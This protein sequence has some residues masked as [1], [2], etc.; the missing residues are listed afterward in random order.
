MGE[1]TVL[2]KKRGDL[3]KIGL[4]PKMF[5]Q[6]RYEPKGQGEYEGEYRGTTL[7]GSR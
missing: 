5:N 4:I 6:D 2:L 3:S 7:L 1:E